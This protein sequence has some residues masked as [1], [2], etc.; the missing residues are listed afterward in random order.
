MKLK[1]R[2]DKEDFIIFIIFAIF[3]L[4][5]VAIGV[6]NLHSFATEGTFS[7]LNPFPA[8]S[9]DFLWITLTIYICALVGMLI[10]VKSYFFYV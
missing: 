7:T 4:Y 6:V 8:F 3:L 10:S 1:F 9:P 5:I 2:A